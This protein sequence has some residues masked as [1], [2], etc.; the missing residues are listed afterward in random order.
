VGVALRDLRLI[1]KFEKQ[2]CPSWKSLRPRGRGAA[3]GVYPEEDDDMQRSETMLAAALL[4]LSCGSSGSGPQGGG[5]ET[6][7]GQLTGTALGAFVCISG[8]D[9]WYD[10]SSQLSLVAPSPGLVSLMN[11]AQYPT[12]LN[13]TFSNTETAHENSGFAC[14]PQPSVVSTTTPSTAVS[15]RALQNQLMV[16]A[17]SIL[18]PAHFRYSTTWDAFDTA[19]LLLVPRQIGPTTITGDWQATRP[20]GSS[21]AVVLSGTFTLTRTSGGGPQPPGGVTGSAANG[22]VTVSW[23][24]V[25][26]ATSYNFYFATQSGVT[27]ANYATLPGGTR[28]TSVSSP[29]TLTGL[30]N[31]TA[32]FIVVTAVGAGGEGAASSEITAT[33]SASGGAGEIFISDQ[34]APAIRV[35]SR[36]VSGSAAPLRSIAGAAT[37]LSAPRGLSVDVADAEVAVAD[38]SSVRVFARTASGNVAPLRT[39]SA[40]NVAGVRVDAAHGEIATSD[41]SQMIFF[42]PRTATGSPAALRS[43]QAVPTGGGSLALYDFAVDAVN[44]EVLAVTGIST[45]AP[46]QVLAYSR[47][48]TGTPTPLRTLTVLPNQATSYAALAVDTANGE[49]WVT[50]VGQTSATSGTFVFARTAS[51]SATP[52]RQ[53]A[54]SGRG[55]Y[56]DAADGEVGLLTNG[57]GF[58]VISRTTL[59]TLRSA[60]TPSI[61]GTA[62]GVDFGP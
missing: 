15:I 39:F 30:S 47:T 27:P 51:G 23:S 1:F 17:G 20:A 50:V 31:G 45:S 59:A 10:E 62:S 41:G 12:N 53:A 28:V 5:S 16:T 33:P 44:N 14:A 56:L 11:T 49:L 18:I 8:T 6:W 7:T 61:G 34:A 3:L 37:T 13:G 35:F 4:C 24:A 9:G 60:T 36:T 26:G 42:Y 46:V 38:S 32:Y 57:G 19:R 48:A 58:T 22:S 21:S 2:T 29:Y 43:F 25:A 40:S 55:L 54:V 52:L